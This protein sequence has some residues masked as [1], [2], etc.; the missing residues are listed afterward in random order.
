MVCVCVCVLCVVCCCAA[1]CVSVWFICVREG[2]LNARGF[3]WLQGKATVRAR[4][5]ECGPRFTLKLRSLQVCCA[6]ITAAA[7]ATAAAILHVLFVLFVFLFPS[8]SPAAPHPPE[9][10][11]SPFLTAPSL[12]GAFCCRQAVSNHL[13]L[14]RRLQLGTFDTRHGEYEWYHNTEMDTSRRR[15]HV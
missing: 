7:A 11:R 8:P 12:P 14:H 2:L 13:L 9:R 1:L 10:L 6:P 5:Q 4:L 15:F 3:V